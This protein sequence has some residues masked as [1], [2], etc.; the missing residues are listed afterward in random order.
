MSDMNVGGQA[1]IE[2]VMMRTPHAFT[3]AVRAPD[4]TIV[5]KEDNWRSIW[6]KMTFLR[7]PFL[8]G[9]VVMIE[10]LVNGLQALTFA[11]TVATPEEESSNAAAQSTNSDATSAEGGASTVHSTPAPSALS[12][13]QLTVTIASSLGMGLVMFVA[14]PHLLTAGLGWLLGSELLNPDG[15]LFHIVDGIIKLGIF[16]AYIALISMMEDIRRVFQYHGA[17]HKSVYAFEAGVP[18]TVE[19]V[20]QYSTLHP[21]CGTSF[22]MFVMLV[23][24]FLFSAV[25]PLFMPAFDG[26]PAIVRNLIMVAIKIPLMLPVAGISYEAIRFSGK[27]PNNPVLGLL[28]KPGLWMQRLTTKEPSDAQLEVAIAA[29]S[30]A[31]EREARWQDE[32]GQRLAGNASSAAAALSAAAS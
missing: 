24:I 18:L 14:L 26:M 17:E 21:R 29:L 5:L 1:V 22:L 20:R 12:N 8:R 16:V 4:G 11:A 28:S 7:W 32:A 23:S 15:V 13:W 9:T 10:A 27:F 25:F 3:V 30:K 2:G 6:D 19:N 31:L